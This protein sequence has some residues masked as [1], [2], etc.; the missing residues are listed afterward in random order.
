MKIH[1]IEKGIEVPFGNRRTVYP[2]KE[3]EV[4]DSF[5]VTPADYEELRTVARRIPPSANRF[6]KNHNM[7]FSIRLMKKE[8][9]IRVWRVK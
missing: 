4:G 2:F 5:L 6:G 3:M 1:E 9:G 7:K 8:N